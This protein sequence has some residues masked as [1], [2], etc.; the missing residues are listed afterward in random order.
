VFYCAPAVARRLGSVTGM[1]L[2]ATTAQ[3]DATFR[4]DRLEP[5]NTQVVVA[6][7]LVLAFSASGLVGTFRDAAHRMTPNERW[8]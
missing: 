2:I 6:K 4:G 1:I 3:L 5:G 8:C 7:L